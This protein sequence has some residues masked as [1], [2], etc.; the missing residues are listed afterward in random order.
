MSSDVMLHFKQTLSSEQRRSL[1]EYLK[2]RLRIA[3]D[4]HE[5]GKPH[6]LFVPVDPATA[7]P[8]RVLAAVRER[9]YD[10]RLVDL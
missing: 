3:G 2:D 10:A 5:S 4:V 7:S 1:L 8:H 9:G 6:L